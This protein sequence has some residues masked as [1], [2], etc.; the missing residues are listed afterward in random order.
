V[1]LVGIELFEEEFVVAR[2][3]AEV[4]WFVRQNDAWIHCASYPGARSERLDAGAGTVYRSRVEL[5]V[6]AKTRLMR[7]ESRPARPARKSALEHL[8]RPRTNVARDTRRSYYLVGARGA[9]LQDR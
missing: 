5:E 8:L 1:S 3:T 6:P 7:V 4:H 2:G 9:L